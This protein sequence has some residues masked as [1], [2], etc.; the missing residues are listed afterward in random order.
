MSNKSLVIYIVSIV[1]IVLM[2]GGCS[3]FGARK[4]PYAKHVTI[5]PPDRFAS[6]FI[7]LERAFRRRDLDTTMDCFERSCSKDYPVILRYLTDVYRRGDKLSLQLYRVKSVE[8]LGRMVYQIN[9]KRAY[10]DIY[11]RTWHKARGEADFILSLGEVPEI[12]EVRGDNP[13]TP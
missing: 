5:R 2:A 7:R 6:L 1:L 8:R 10:F 9:W 4:G 3:K 13:L 11:D 12:L